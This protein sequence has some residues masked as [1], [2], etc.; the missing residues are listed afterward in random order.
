MII[1]S[2]YHGCICQICNGVSGY[3]EG[4]QISKLLHSQITNHGNIN[5]RPSNILVAHQLFVNF[6]IK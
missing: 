6:L 2:A 5:M 4:G 1:F 3:R